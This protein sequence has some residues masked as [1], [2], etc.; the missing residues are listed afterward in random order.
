MINGALSDSH[1][2]FELPHGLGSAADHLGS[3]TAIRR[4]FPRSVKIHLFIWARLFITDDTVSKRFVKISNVNISNTLIFFD[5]LKASHTFS[6][7][8]LVYFN[9]KNI[10]VF[11]YKVKHLTI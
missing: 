3:I 1:L 5:C 6:T 4:V 11:G 7:K 9:T 10:S 2:S 8:I